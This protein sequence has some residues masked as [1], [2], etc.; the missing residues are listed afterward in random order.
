MKERESITVRDGN[1]ICCRSDPNTNSAE[2]TAATTHSIMDRERTT[3]AKDVL[4]ARE[5]RS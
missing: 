3:S 2:P 4:S 5:V 1:T